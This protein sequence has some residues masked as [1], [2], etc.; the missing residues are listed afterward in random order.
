V[1]LVQGLSTCLL[2]RLALQIQQGHLHAL[3]RSGQIEPLD[4]SERRRL[5]AALLRSEFA[6]RG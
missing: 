3:H 2:N 1:G 6:G 4:H 5:R